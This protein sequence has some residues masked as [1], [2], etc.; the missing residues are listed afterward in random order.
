AEEQIFEPREALDLL[1]EEAV[2][3][4]EGRRRDWRKAERLED[5]RHHVVA[6]RSV[7]AELEPL[8]DRPVAARQRQPEVGDEPRAQ[9][10]P[11]RAVAGVTF[12]EQMQEAALALR[13]RELVEH[14]REDDVLDYRATHLVTGD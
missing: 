14:L 5:R 1:L 11:R 3:L 8:R 9:R 12:A 4:T 6:I 13:G 10:P 7:V 2:R